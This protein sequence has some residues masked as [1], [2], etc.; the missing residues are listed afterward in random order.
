MHFCM[1]ILCVSV[2]IY[3]TGACLL[4]GLGMTCTEGELKGPRPSAV[5]A[6]TVTLYKTFCSKFMTIPLNPVKL[7][8]STSSVEIRKTW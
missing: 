4:V 2:L 7:I 5:K 3:H 1:E 8:L 6:L